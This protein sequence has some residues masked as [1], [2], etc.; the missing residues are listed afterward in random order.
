MGFRT[1]L[2]L[3]LTSFPARAEEPLSRE[4]L[5]ERLSVLEKTSAREKAA[6]D[7]VRSRWARELEQTREARRVLAAEVLGLQ[8]ERQD[9]LH[10]AG[11]LEREKKAAAARWKALVD[12]MQ[13]VSDQRRQVA[14]QIDVY[15][16]EIPGEDDAAQNLPA[17]VERLHIDG[18]RVGTKE[19]MLRT[20]SGVRERVTLLAAGHVA[21]AYRTTQGGRVGM[22]LASPADASGYRWTEALEDTQREAIA[23]AIEAVERG[24]AEVAVPLDVSGRLRRDATTESAGLAGLWQAGGPVMYPLAFVA[25]FAFLLIAERTWFLLRQ[26][27]RSGLL[28]DVLSACRQGQYEAAERMSTE[29]GGVVGRT[30][31]ACLR[32]RTSGPTAMEDGISEQLLHEMPRLNRFLGGIAT[33]G[34][35]APLLGLLGTVT[36]IIQTFGVIK[37]YS[38]ANPGLMA[39]GISEALV[40]TAT[41]L[42]IAIPILLVHSL[43]SG[44]MDGIV[45]DAEKSTATLYN[46]L[47]GD[48]ACAS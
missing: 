38:N 28:A 10:R 25:L 14:E 42:V 36:G 19:T 34:A 24:D 3:F 23:A 17:L 37:I 32:R 22:A 16:S 35:V 39:G 29:T 40:T 44:R 15:R 12:G 33:L 45:S 46:T 1:L 30:L 21:F 7:E 5:S 20:A 27:R 11:G 31:A 13:R 43:L 48:E 9:L 18:T 8:M 4:E 2:I 26:K 41:G 6:L 47:Q